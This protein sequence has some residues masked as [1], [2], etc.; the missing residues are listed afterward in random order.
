MINDNFFNIIKNKIVSFVDKASRKRKLFLFIFFLPSLLFF[1]FSEIR[2]FLYSCNILKSKKINNIVVSVGSIFV[3]GVGKT[4]IVKELAEAL[5]EKNIKVAILLRGYKSMIEA[6]NKNISIR[7]S[8][9]INWRVI[10][11]EAFMLASNLKKTTFVIGKDRLK[12]AELVGNKDLIILDDGAQYKKLKKDFEIFVLKGKDILKKNFFLPM[13][14]LRESFYKL[15]N[16]D[17]LVIN[18]EKETF[19]IIINRLKK[20]S[21]API[22]GINYYIKEIKNL[23][24]DKIIKLKKA[25][26]I[27]CFCSLGDPDNFKYLLKS[28]GYDIVYSMTKLDHAPFSVKEL[29]DIIKVA[30]NKKAKYLICSE[31]DKV[32]LCNVFFNM[33][34]LYVKININMLFGKECWEKF[35]RK[36]SNNVNT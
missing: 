6:S 16:A 3:G 10:G 22:V 4:P 17:L 33:P 15:K 31:K 18:I 20:Y 24:D 13:G 9:K 26:K 25:D 11:D 35:I 30:Q 23:N 7:S 14:R 8:D 28:Y 1:I 19:N 29:K 5:M 21:N 36:L 2:S 32:K 27:A 34:I 12:S